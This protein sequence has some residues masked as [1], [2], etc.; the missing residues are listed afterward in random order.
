ML[1]PIT[2][3]ASVRSLAATAPALFRVLAARSAEDVQL[4]VAGV[5]G[6]QEYVVPPEDLE[7]VRQFITI[8]SR[9]G[10][11]TRDLTGQEHPER[12]VEVRKGVEAGPLDAGPPVGAQE[13]RKLSPEELKIALAKGGLERVN[14]KLQL[15]LPRAKARHR[16]ARRLR[17]GGSLAALASN[18]GVLGAIGIGNAAASMTAAIIALLVSGAKVI[19]DHLIAGVAGDKPMRLQE[20]LVQTNAL[21][22]EVG[23]LLQ[24]FSRLSAAGA[25]YSAYP[26]ESANRVAAELAKLLPELDLTLE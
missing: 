7:R 9:E 26:L 20:L 5:A 4:R 8:E 19:E 1:D 10:A 22:Y 15:A 6:K 14:T 3:A 23:E 13:N 11:T 16:L 17:L 24:S 25:D 18:V 12:T 2:V 21:H